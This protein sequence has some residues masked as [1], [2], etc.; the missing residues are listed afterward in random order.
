MNISNDTAERMQ[1]AADYTRTAITYIVGLIT[2]LNGIA[3]M[4]VYTPA[5]GAAFI[6]AGFV[7][8]PEV[9]AKIAVKTGTDMTTI[10][11]LGAY[12][13]LFI[14]GAALGLSQVDMS[15]APEIIPGT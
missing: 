7:L 5:G 8:I 3:Y 1:L 4:M 6:G 13:I 14:T 15:Q 12:G 2:I 11:I 9:Q 10:T